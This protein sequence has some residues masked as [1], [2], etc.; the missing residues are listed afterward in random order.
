MVSRRY[1]EW[2]YAQLHDGADAAILGGNT[3]GPPSMLTGSHDGS[4]MGVFCR[5]AAAIKD[6]SLLIKLQ[7]YLPIGL[8]PVLIHLPACRSRGRIDERQTMATDVARL[9]F[10]PGAAL[11]AASSRS[12]AGSASRRSRTSSGSS[13]PRSAARNCSTSSARPAP[14]TTA[15]RCPAPAARLTVGA[16]T[17]YVGGLRVELDADL[18]YTQQPDWL[19][20]PAR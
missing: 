20:Q 3:G 8:S 12:R 2:G 11:H 17:M 19:D 15:T 4:E 14:R 13:T 16:G 7:E 18:D 1:G 9:S 10:D 5:D 6:R